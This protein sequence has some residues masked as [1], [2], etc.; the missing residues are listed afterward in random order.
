MLDHDEHGTA[1]SHVY[2][3]DRGQLTGDAHEVQVNASLLLQQ[4]EPHVAAT[5]TATAATG[6]VAVAA[7]PSSRPA[8]PTG[9]VRWDSA[10]E[11]HGRVEDSAGSKVSSSYNLMPSD[12]CVMDDV[13]SSNLLEAYA[14][15]DAIQHPVQCSP[16]HCVSTASGCNAEAGSSAGHQATLQTA[17]K[18]VTHASRGKTLGRCMLSVLKVLVTHTQRL[19]RKSK[20]CAGSIWG[21]GLVEAAL[22]VLNV[23]YSEGFS[24]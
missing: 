6:P 11:R 18:V 3:S 2:V 5:A 12:K 1:D 23:F 21:A 24:S 7:A 4:P 13:S 14:Y 8:T 16:S 22:V 19:M 15:L 10:S 20:F 9:M 17:S